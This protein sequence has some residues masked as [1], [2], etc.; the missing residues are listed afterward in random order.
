MFRQTEESTASQDNSVTSTANGI[1]LESNAGGESAKDQ[2]VESSLDDTFASTSDETLRRTPTSVSSD[3]VRDIQKDDQ[4]D[5]T[6]NSTQ[7]KSEFKNILAALNHVGCG[8]LLQTFIDQDVD[9]E[10]AAHLIGVG[11]IKSART[12]L[13]D[14]LGLN[15]VGKRVRFIEKFKGKFVSPSKSRTLTSNT[16]R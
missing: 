6:L 7:P 2:N 13:A 1:S 3:N 10:V 14:E 5:D 11:E 15:A 16:S 12:T 4:P 8:G 9:D